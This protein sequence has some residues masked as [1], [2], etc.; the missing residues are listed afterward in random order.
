MSRSDIPEKLSLGMQSK[1]CD[2]QACLIELLRSQEGGF[3]RLFIFKFRICFFIL[4]GNVCLW[5][6]S[7]S[8]SVVFSF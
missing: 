1:L 4:V 7:I 6:I 8:N 2:L 3:C 5:W